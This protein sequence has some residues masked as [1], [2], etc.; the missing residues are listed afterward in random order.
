MLSLR[1][2]G[3]LTLIGLS[4]CEQAAARYMW[5]E[6]D[7]R[8][9]ALYP[10]RFGQEHPAVIDKLSQACP[11]QICGTLSG[12]A[13]TPL[14]AAQGECTQQDMAD[15]IIGTSIDPPGQLNTDALHSDAA[16]QF[17]DA[18]KANMI[19][20]AIEYRQAEKNTP[21]VRHAV[22]TLE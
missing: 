19:A 16:Q 13:I 15:S 14:L 5:L 1:F 20:L 8:F 10:R 9:V 4:L 18:T 2:A 22:F 3:L 12:L 11:G 7:D 6:R 17:D 21:P